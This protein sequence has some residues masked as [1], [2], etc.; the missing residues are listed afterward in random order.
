MLEI[1]LL[2]T[3]AYR[4]YEEYEEFWSGLDRNGLRLS[5]MEKR[6]LVFSLTWFFPLQPNLQKLEGSGGGSGGSK[7]Q[8][9]LRLFCLESNPASPR[10]LKK[11]KGSHS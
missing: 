7:D 6:T 5:F 2:T 10:A 9:G 3:T 1:V 8:A 11:P 4:L